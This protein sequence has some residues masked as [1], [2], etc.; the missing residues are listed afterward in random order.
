[1]DSDQCFIC[2]KKL[3]LIEITIQKCKCE[4]VFCKKHKEP[5]DHQCTYN[6]FQV[7]SNLLQNEL[8]PIIANKII[9][10]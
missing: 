5:M 7:N 10:L 4:N 1:M 2:Q 8:K 9:R 6:Y 3:K